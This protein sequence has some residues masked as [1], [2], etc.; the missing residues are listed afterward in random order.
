[1]EDP[2]TIKSDPDGRSLKR[3]RPAVLIRGAGCAGV[4][5]VFWMQKLGNADTLVEVL[6]GP[7]KVGTFV[8]VEG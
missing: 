3:R 8:A 7:R 5:I 6:S 4:T 1:M 2:S